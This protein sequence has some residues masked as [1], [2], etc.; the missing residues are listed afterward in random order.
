MLN[1]ENM[2]YLYITVVLLLAALCNI[3]AQEIALSF[4]LNNEINETKEYQAK[5]VI[6]LSD[7]FH[8]K[9]DN[10][11]TFRALINNELEFLPTSETYIDE[12]G[13]P[14]E[15]SSGSYVVGDIPGQLNVSSSGAANYSIP[16]E[17][18]AGIQGVQPSFSI[19]YNSHGAMGLVGYKAGLNG[20][21]A[22][23]RV[24][25]NTYYDEDHHP[26]SFDEDDRFALDGRRLLLTSNDDYGDAGST[27]ATEV[28]NYAVITANGRVGD[29]PESFTV[30]LKDGTIMTYGL[31]DNSSMKLQGY[32]GTYAWYLSK[33]KDRNG[34]YIRYIYG[35]KSDGETWL[36]E[37]KYTCNDI[38]SLNG[39]YSL[40]FEYS[41]VNLV[42]KYIAGKKLTPSKRLSKIWIKY[43]EQDLYHYSIGYSYDKLSSVTKISN[44]GEKIKP[45]RFYWNNNSSDDVTTVESSSFKDIHTGNFRGIGQNELVTIQGTDAVFSEYLKSSKTWNELKRIPLYYSDYKIERIADIDNDCVD[46]VVIS[47]FYTVSSSMG[48]DD[49]YVHVIKIVDFNDDSSSKFSVDLTNS[50][51]HSPHVLVGDFKGIKSLQ[52]LRI[53]SYYNSPAHLGQIISNGLSE[54]VYTNTNIN[55][56][57][58]GFKN[59]YVGDFNA[60]G[61]SDLLAHYSGKIEIYS[62]END[63]FV[64][65]KTITKATNKIQIADFNAD[66]TSDIYITEPENKI[67]YCNGFELMDS[68]AGPWFRME[69]P[70]LE[71]IGDFDEYVNGAVT[72]PRERE[73]EFIYAANLNGDELADIVV[74]GIYREEFSFAWDQFLNPGET[75][76]L[77][78]GNA[79]AQR[80][81]AKV[82]EFCN[83][84]G[85]DNR[86]AGVETIPVAIETNAGPRL[87][88]IIV[89]VSYYG[90]SF[91]KQLKDGSFWNVKNM[92]YTRNVLEDFTEIVHAD[93]SGDGIKSV[94]V[95]S[96][97]FLEKF[98]NGIRQPYV[99]N[100]YQS[101]GGKY[102]ITTSIYGAGLYPYYV[103]SDANLSVYNGSMPVTSS[104]VKPD[105]HTIKYKYGKG[106]MHFNG[107][108]FIGF[109]HIE[110]QICEPESTTH[111]SKI[112]KEF[113]VKSKDNFY[114]LVPSQTE[115][116]IENESQNV[117]E[118]SY[119]LDYVSGETKRFTLRKTQDI[120]TDSKLGNEWYTSYRDYNTDGNPETIEKVCGNY[121]ETKSIS[122]PPSG[123]WKKT[124]PESV[125][126]S[127]NLEVIE[128][129]DYTYYSNGNLETETVNDDLETT[130]SEYDNVGNPRKV[131]IKAIARDA[132]D[133]E[134]E[135]AY[136]TTDYIYT[137]DYRFV[138]I[139]TNA[140]SGVTISYDYYFDKGLIKS[141]TSP[142]ETISYKYDN[143]GRVIEESSSLGNWTKTSR[144]WVLDDEPAGAKFFIAQIS[145]VNQ[146]VPSKVWYDKLGREIRVDSPVND[147]TSMVVKVYNNRGQIESISEPYF[148]GSP[149]KTTY[150]YNADGTTATV[151][152]V[153]NRE[154]S[155]AYGVSA[156]NGEKITIT[157]P[158]G[159]KITESNFLGQVKRTT[160]FNGS[161]VEHYYYNSGLVSKS[162]ASLGGPDGVTMEYDKY[163]NRTKLN[164]PNTGVIKTLYNPFGQILSHDD[165]KGNATTYKYKSDGRLDETTTGDLKLKHEYTNQLLLDRITKT[166]N[167]SIIH[168]QDFDYDANTFLLSSKTETIDGKTFKE[169][170]RAHV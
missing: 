1:Q 64:L 103:S 170:G 156:Y 166:D 39:A 60:D 78:E 92:L 45:A 63:V 88:N 37:V 143:F 119:A 126:N 89:K 139:K 8:F 33:V 123:W 161:T 127:V 114:T 5:D 40:I 28:E 130:Y 90:T 134:I 24:A 30:E 14:T 84:L 137:T 94:Y 46:E 73:N 159:D 97:G 3:A 168:V 142:L 155:Y 153:N 83:R 96:N 55:L 100:I 50:P 32:T 107:K 101:N 72:Q 31:L 71:W 150:T 86:V 115:T 20:L 59:F 152:D 93:F 62:M 162:V 43:G 157:T 17:I 145:S 138:D 75:G 4:N 109:A 41:D 144:Q 124:K 51:H 113:E 44:N 6:K 106:L 35:N 57:S 118:F 13:E 54:E 74:N 25:H 77:E 129:T 2:K 9:A 80:M 19:V 158:L 29:A 169:I 117:N 131:K 48:E 164:D 69:V 128:S 141:E 76:T 18:P 112:V 147:Q 125:T 82:T 122:Y 52:T 85:E 98:Y 49:Y 132:D 38:A 104:V 121:R 47:R 133:Q 34:N 99:Q 21:S 7:G 136:R 67:Y 167:G 23:R 68:K 91:Y 108:G 110:N 15:E 11:S 27:Y 120:A 10:N 160:D 36:Q 61:K 163:G 146:G 42:S 95:R 116:F 56:I 140:E 102:T 154:T 79:A 111:Y 12:N 81:D 148:D 26:I 105:G 58:S 165:N 135:T 22:I 149:R 151:T 65:K 70:D 53:C 16:I 87:L 66:G